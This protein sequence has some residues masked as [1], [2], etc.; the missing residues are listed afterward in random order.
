MLDPKVF[1]EFSARLGAM[2]AASP[3]ADIEKNARALLSGL[4]AKLDL[5]SREE[6]DVQAQ[7]LQRTREMLKALEERV[8]R[9][10]SRHS[11]AA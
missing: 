4:F 9:L 10:E 5:V 8:A 6:F 3:A 1:E 2:L 11:D 7:V